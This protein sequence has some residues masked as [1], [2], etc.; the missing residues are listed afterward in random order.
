MA[1]GYSTRH[2]SYS[3][4]IKRRF[5]FIYT[6]FQ[7]G[8]TLGMEAILPLGPLNTKT[9][10]TNYIHICYTQIANI[11]SANLKLLAVQVYRYRLKC[12][13][14]NMFFLP[15][16]RTGK[17]AERLC[18][19]VTF[20]FPPCSVSIDCIYSAYLFK[21]LLLSHSPRI[22]QNIVDSEYTKIK[23]CSY[24]PNGIHTEEEQYPGYIKH[25]E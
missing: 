16:P 6:I 13:T 9:N 17:V 25:L 12:E 7:E 24:L 3:K 15:I 4:H 14:I 18:T 22:R 10:K 1:F 11:N 21:N 2:T 23:D 5:I 20:L 8:D 19:C